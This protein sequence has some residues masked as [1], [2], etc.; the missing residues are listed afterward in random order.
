MDNLKQKTMYKL[1]LFLSFFFFIGSINAQT[2]PIKKKAYVDEQKILN[3]EAA[4]PRAGYISAPYRKADG[5]WYEKTDAGVEQLIIDTV[6]MLATKYD[7]QNV[8]VDTLNEIATKYDLSNV[9]VDTINEIATK[10]DLSNVNVDTVLE[11]ATKYDLTQI[12]TGS[13]DT[14]NEIATK[15]DLLQNPTFANLNKAEKFQAKIARINK[16]EKVKAKII[17]FGDSNTTPPARFLTQLKEEY[18]SRYDSTG[19]GWHSASGINFNPTGRWKSITGTTTAEGIPNG[20][21]LINDH[22]IM[23]SGAIIGFNGLTTTGGKLTDSVTVYYE[24]GTGDFA[25]SIN[26]GA[27]TTVENSTGTGLGILAIEPGLVSNYSINIRSDETGFTIFGVNTEVKNTGGV[28]IHKAGYAGYAVYDLADLTKKSLFQEIITSLNPDLVIINLGSN[29]TGFDSF[30]GNNTTPNG[31]MLNMDTVIANIRIADS[32]DIML[33]APSDLAREQ[34]EGTAHPIPMSLYNDAYYKYAVK[35]NIAYASL[36]NWHGNGFTALENGILLDQ[37]HYSDVGAERNFDFLCEALQVKERRYEEPI[38]SEFWT[39]SNGGIYYTPNVSI[40]TTPT[41]GVKLDI[42][43]G[44]SDNTE[45][46]L[47]I[48][49]SINNHFVHFRN[50]NKVAFGTL[51]QYD[52]MVNVVGNMKFYDSKLTFQGANNNFIPFTFQFGGSWSPVIM[53]YYENLSQ[54]WKVQHNASLNAMYFETFDNHNFIFNSAKNIE[55]KGNKL[56]LFQ[57]GI[58]S[59]KLTSSFGG[60]A[61]WQ[62]GNLLLNYTNANN[63]FKINHGSSWSKQAITFTENNVDAWYLKHNGAGNIGGIGSK[64]GYNLLF[65]TEGNNSITLKTNSVD[66]FIVNGDGSTRLLQYGSGTITGTAA[67]YLA[68]ESDGDV[69][70]VDP[71]AGMDAVV[72]NRSYVDNTAALVDLSSGQV[73]YNTT[74]NAFVVLP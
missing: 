10:Y 41:T 14:I 45:H 3:V 6:G 7:L 22:L 25:W 60:E 74:S 70:E 59:M 24:K 36:Y 52:E 15:Y 63:S 47:L 38:L 69:I 27:Y 32:C 50:D 40:G 34:G 37:V 73:Y 13:V 9:N 64:S 18:W 72:A 17:F 61:T 12:A 8:S 2:A 62:N 19:T 35:N 21:G 20:S 33:L 44:T 58:D 28:I 4:T 46:S 56:L 67:K 51:P 23:D 54:K 11:I 48:G 5:N 30:L 55:L 53:D 71:A 57:I 26:V 16:G 68:V 49:N 42:R 1:F 43:G 29:G 31:T 39:E 66:R 65:E